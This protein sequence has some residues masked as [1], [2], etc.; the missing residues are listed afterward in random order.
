MRNVWTGCTSLLLWEIRVVLPVC[1]QIYDENETMWVVEVVPAEGQYAGHRILDD[2]TWHALTPRLQTLQVDGAVLSCQYD[3]RSAPTSSFIFLLYCIPSPSVSCFSF[4]KC[5]CMYKDEDFFFH[6][7]ILCPP[8][9]DP[10]TA[11]AHPAA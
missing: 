11:A 4:I 5:L 2:R 9:L 7:Q 1:V 3:R 8:G 10:P 6:S